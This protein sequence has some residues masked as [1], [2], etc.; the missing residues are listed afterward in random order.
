MGKG[1][2]DEAYK[3]FNKGQYSQFNIL[4]NWAVKNEPH[5]PAPPLAHALLLTAETGTR[6]WY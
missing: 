3:V 2:F 1:S 5:R 6:W 4:A